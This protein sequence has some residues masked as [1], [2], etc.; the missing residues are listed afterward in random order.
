MRLLG[1]LDLIVFFWFARIKIQNEINID[2]D[3]QE[4]IHLIFEH[5]II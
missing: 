5:L 1:I 3:S 2:R 4:K